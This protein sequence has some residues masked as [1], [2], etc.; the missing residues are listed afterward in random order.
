VVYRDNATAYFKEMIFANGSWG[1]PV[2]IMSATSSHYPAMVILSDKSVLM[3]YQDMSVGLRQIVRDGSTGVWGTPSTLEASL[4]ETVTLLILP[5]TRIML[6]YRDY[7][8]SYLR[9]KIR[10]LNQS[11]GAYSVIG[12]VSYDNISI[13]MGAL[14]QV[15]LILED[16]SQYV[17]ERLDTSASS[18]I[19]VSDTQHPLKIWVSTIDPVSGDGRDGDIWFKG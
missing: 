15:M 7:S 2:N 13:S 6:V 17:V 14:G 5:D 1:S 19:P 4:V 12:T 18:A 10:D 9:Q 16:S 11:W 3:A 8:S